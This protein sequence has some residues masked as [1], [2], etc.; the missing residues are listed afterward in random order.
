MAAVTHITDAASYTA[1]KSTKAAK[2]VGRKSAK[3]ANA[4]LSFAQGFGSFALKVLWYMLIINLMGMGFVALGL[5]AEWA[6]VPFFF[7][8]W[9]G[10]I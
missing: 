3:T 1:R 7:L 4:T 2:F 10:I 9:K 5:A 8:V 6:I